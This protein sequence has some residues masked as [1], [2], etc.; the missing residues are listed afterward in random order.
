MAHLANFM[1]TCGYGARASWTLRMSLLVSGTAKV[2][3]C[4]KMYHHAC[5]ISLGAEKV[6]RHFVNQR[7][8]LSQT[9]SEKHE[10]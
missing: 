2:F 1:E 10:F 5:A 4:Q 7:R 8:R 9:V 3:M 6:K